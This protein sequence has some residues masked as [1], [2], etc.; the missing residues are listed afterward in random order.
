MVKTVT[1]GTNQLL[2]TIRDTRETLAQRL[3]ENIDP[4]TSML[5]KF[6]SLRRK[7][8]ILSSQNRTL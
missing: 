3:Y 8:E 4:K 5:E 6:E 7:C 2:R 1:E